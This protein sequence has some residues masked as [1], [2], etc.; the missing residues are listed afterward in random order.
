MEKISIAVWPRGSGL[1]LG[2]AASVPTMIRM[3]LLRRLSRQARCKVACSLFGGQMSI[4]FYSRLAS[5]MMHL[6]GD[7]EAQA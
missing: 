5:S 1:G 6:G 2:F 7:L 3:E 4:S